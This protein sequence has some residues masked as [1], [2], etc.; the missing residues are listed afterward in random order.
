MRKGP[1]HAS[2]CLAVFFLFGVS[3]AAADSTTPSQFSTEL[4]WGYEVQSSPLVRIS[5]EGTLI[6]L[7]GQQRSSATHV[8]VGAEGYTNWTLG[9]GWGVTLAGIANMKRAPSAPDFDFSSVS[10][11]PGLYTVLGSVSLGWGLTWEHLYVAGRPFREVRGTQLNWTQADLD[12]GMWAVIGD[13]AINR[14]PDELA[15][16]D[17]SMA[18]LVLQRHLTKLMAGIDALDLSA[19]VTRE[20]NEKGFSYLSYR[21]VMLSASLQWSWLDITWS[22]SPTWQRAQFDEVAFSEEP[23]RVDQSIG[24]GFSAER[25]LSAKNTLR[26]GYDDVRNNS[27]TNM[28]DNRYQQFTVTLYTDW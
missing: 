27:T 4:G 15:D 26:V 25:A 5:P 7:D 6:N 21:N 28:F 22:V 8:R 16:L 2:V 13:I 18:S 24:F 23:S 1:Y 20:H 10:V 14:H 17:S 9:E 12:G 11:Q 3:Y 19:Y